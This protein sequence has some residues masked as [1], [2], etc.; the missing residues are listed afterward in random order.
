MEQICKECNQPFTL[1][2]QD[3][4]FFEG[5]GL[6][7]PKRCYQCRQKRRD[8]KKIVDMKSCIGK[9]IA[10]TKASV[11]GDRSYVGDNNKVLLLGV[12]DDGTLVI[13]GKWFWE[14][15]TEST[16]SPDFND[17]YWKVVEEKGGE[18]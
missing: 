14:K 5:R 10:R 7:L 12:R 2:V 15:G 13:E 1:S 3:K 11:H 17:G 18:K 9:Y 16:L 8:D 4:H 6:S